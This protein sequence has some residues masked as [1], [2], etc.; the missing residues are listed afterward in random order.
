M[1]QK[2]LKVIKQTKQAVGNFCLTF[3]KFCLGIAV[4]MMICSYKSY[5]TKQ[6]FTNCVN[7]LVVKQL[8][9]QKDSI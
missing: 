7:E 6:D 3:T 4:G 5:L 1:K 9:I 8:E 2:T